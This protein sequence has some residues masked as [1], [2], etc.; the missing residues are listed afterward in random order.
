MKIAFGVDPG[1]LDLRESILAHLKEAG[2]EVVEVGS[3]DSE[4]VVPYNPAGGH[5]AESFA[6]LPKSGR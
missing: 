2:H 5:A 6:W 1:G 3:T 4:N